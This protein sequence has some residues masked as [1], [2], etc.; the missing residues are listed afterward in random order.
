MSRSMNLANCVEIHISHYNL[1]PEL[2]VRKLCSQNFL[3]QLPGLDFKTNKE[4]HCLNLVGE[5]CVVLYSTTFQLCH[6]VVPQHL[7]VKGVQLFNQCL[8]YRHSRRIILPVFSFY[9]RVHES[10]NLMRIKTFVD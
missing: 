8:T 2:F 7:D 10:R 9:C 3:S 5:V 6:H 4:R 1:A